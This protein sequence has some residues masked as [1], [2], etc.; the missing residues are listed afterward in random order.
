VSDEPVPPRD[1]NPAVPMGLQQIILKAMS[2]DPEARFSS[3]NA[4]IKAL[5]YFVKNPKVVFAQSQG[6][7][8]TVRNRTLEDKNTNPTDEKNTSRPMYPIILGITLAFFV[9]AL[10]SGIYLIAQSDVSH[11]DGLSSIDKLLGV[12]GN[13]SNDRK[14][15]VE[16]FTGKIYDDE[17]KEYLSESGYSVVKV[18][19]D[20]KLNVPENSI[21]NQDPEA[22]ATRIKP[23]GDK[24]IELILYVNMGAVETKMP[25]C[26][27]TEVET[28][29]RYLINEF[30]SMLIDDYDTSGITVEEVES[31][32]VPVDFVVETNPKAGDMI[33]VTKDLKVVLYVSKGSDSETVIMPPVVGQ[34]EAEARRL[35]LESGIALGTATNEY[36]SEIPAGFVIS[37]SVN[38]GEEILAN[39]TPVDLVI[40][41]GPN[42]EYSNIYTGTQS[43]GM[44]TPN[45]SDSPGSVGGLEALLEL[46]GNNEQ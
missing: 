26:E 3:A 23:S 15:Q 41:L 4:M 42:P 28:A 20:R 7:G 6:S 11:T 21:I 46:R 27:L 44:D 13:N 17:F 16:D 14:M 5:D 2:K 9:V 18:I 25:D 34:P 31:D 8:G 43:S 1:I 12:D 33:T 19:Y 29:K 37:A 39:S 24:K 35:I 32:T 30:N 40:S 22:G 36:N 45:Q 38:E 10:I